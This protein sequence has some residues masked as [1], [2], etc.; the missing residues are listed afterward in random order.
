[1]RILLASI[2][3]IALSSGA[4]AYCYPVPDS[5]SEGYV[6]NDLQRSL[7]L[8]EELSQTARDKALRTELDA[9]IGRIERNMLQQRMLQ[10][11]LQVDIM[12]PRP[13]LL[14]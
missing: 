4:Q 6:G 11:Q 1:M 8:N 12:R 9:K 13:Y 10:Q 7:C 2:A 3:L 5:A 14:P